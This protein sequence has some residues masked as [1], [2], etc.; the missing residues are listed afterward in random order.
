MSAPGINTIGKAGNSGESRAHGLEIQEP[1]LTQVDATAILTEL[2]STYSQ[3]APATLGAIHQLFERLGHEASTETSLPNPQAQ[4]RALVEQLPAVVF[5]A[6]MDRGVGEAYVS[7]QLRRRWAFRRRNG[8]K[9]PTPLV[10]A[11]P[12][13]RQRS[14]EYRSGRDVS[15][16]QP[17]RS[18]YRVMARNGSVIWFQCDAW[19]VRRADGRPWPI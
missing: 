12:S 16:G 8:W 4:Y 18:A 10:S 1:E 5:M 7:P 2:A 3:D 9:I 15:F 6:Y 14:L 11:N 19:M 13:R 17:L